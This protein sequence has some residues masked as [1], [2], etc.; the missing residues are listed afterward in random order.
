MTF[1][2]IFF[3]LRHFV[4]EIKSYALFVRFIVLSCGVCPMY[5]FGRLV[6]PVV[7]V[8]MCFSRSERSTWHHTKNTLLQPWNDQK[9]QNPS[10]IEEA[11]EECKAIKSVGV[12]RII[13]KSLKSFQSGYLNSFFITYESSQN[14]LHVIVQTLPRIL[15]GGRN[16]RLSA[17]SGLS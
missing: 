1:R 10:R 2:P 9:C 5:S 12:S 17:S 7:V 14:Q 6:G 16:T 11:V 15:W 3:V 8:Q 13:L 4:H